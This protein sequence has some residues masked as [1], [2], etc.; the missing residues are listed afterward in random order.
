MIIKYVIDLFHTM[1]HL[2]CMHAKC[3]IMACSMPHTPLGL[4]IPYALPFPRNQEPP[5]SHVK[6]FRSYVVFN[7][8]SVPAAQHSFH[9]GSALLFPLI[10]LSVF[11]GKI[12]VSPCPPPPPFPP[13]GYHQPL[14]GVRGRVPSTIYDRPICNA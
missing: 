7:S 11:L 4:A 3:I 6:V 8:R 12:D 9:F 13:S 10:S 5:N 1:I 14:I 2:S